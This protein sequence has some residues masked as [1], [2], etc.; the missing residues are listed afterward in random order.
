[1]MNRENGQTTRI[2]NPQFDNFATNDTTTS[3]L[4]LTPLSLP[5][6]LSIPCRRHHF[7]RPD[8]QLTAIADRLIADFTAALRPPSP[9]LRSHRFR[10]STSSDLLSWTFL[11][12]GSNSCSRDSHNSHRKAQTLAVVIFTFQPTGSNSCSRDSHNSHRYFKELVILS[13]LLLLLPQ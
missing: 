2:D 1:M 11:P 10:H 8:N 4:S 13:Q 9:S 12:T 6:K 5:L 3:S 7:R